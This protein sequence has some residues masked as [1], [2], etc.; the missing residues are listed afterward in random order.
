MRTFV[1]NCDCQSEAPTPLGRISSFPINT[2]KKAD[3]SKQVVDNEDQPTPL[4]RPNSFAKP[5]Q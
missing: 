4:G 2:E 3:E 5:E 1:Q